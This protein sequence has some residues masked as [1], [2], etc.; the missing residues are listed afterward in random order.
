MGALSDRQFDRGMIGPARLVKDRNGVSLM[1]RDKKKEAKE[2]KQGIK[3]Q[4]VAHVRRAFPDCVA[5]FCGQQSGAALVSRTRGFR[6]RDAMGKYRSSI[7]WVDPSYGGEINE[8]W[9]RS[10]VAQSNN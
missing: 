7:I 10:A 6:V 5:E 1:A 2:V 4:V 8:L 3:K 9:V